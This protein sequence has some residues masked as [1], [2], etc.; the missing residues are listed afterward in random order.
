MLTLGSWMACSRACSSGA[1]KLIPFTVSALHLARLGQPAERTNPGGEVV[2]CGQMRQIAAVAAKQYLTQVDQAVDGLLH[3]RDV[4]AS[5]APGGV[6]PC[7][8]A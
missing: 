5:A 4:P 2:Q 8:G 1:K 6:P 3:R 7:G